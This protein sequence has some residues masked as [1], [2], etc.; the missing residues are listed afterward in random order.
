MWWKGL[1]VEGEIVGNPC[2]SLNPTLGKNGK[3]EYHIKTKTHKLITLRFWVAS[4]VNALCG[5]AK[6]SLVLYLPSKSP[7]LKYLTS[8]I[9]IKVTSLISNC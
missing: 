6:V 5:W 3:V 1:T 2:V 9:R 4:D 7:S 8:R